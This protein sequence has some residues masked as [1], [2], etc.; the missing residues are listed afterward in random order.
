MAPP[1]MVNAAIP[2]AIK[3]DVAAI[4]ALCGEGCANN[5]NRTGSKCLLDVVVF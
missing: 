1:N 5:K 2:L 3:Q 4:V